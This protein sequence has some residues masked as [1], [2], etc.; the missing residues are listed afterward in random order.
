MAS[1]DA[2]S[3]EEEDL[4]D[5]ST[6]KVKFDEGSDIVMVTSQPDN[7]SPSSTPKLKASYKDMMTASEVFDFN[8]NDMV[9]AVIEE[10]SLIQWILMKFTISSPMPNIASESTSHMPN[11][12]PESTKIQDS[13]S[14]QLNTH[15]A[16]CFDP[17]MLA[18]NP[19]RRMQKYVNSNQSREGVPNGSKPSGSRFHV[20]TVDTND[21]EES[22][23]SPYIGEPNNFPPKAPPI[24]KSKNV[25]KEPTKNFGAGSNKQVSGKPK[26]VVPPKGKEIIPV[27]GDKLP[28]PIDPEKRIEMRQK[29]Y[30]MLELM[31]RYQAKLKD[32]YLN[33]GNIV[34]ILGGTTSS[35]FWDPPNL[36]SS[37]PTHILAPDI[38]DQ[39]NG[40]QPDVL[41]DKDKQ[42]ENVSSKDKPEPI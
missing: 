17:W 11:P 34:D 8:P 4:R 41:K 29:E 1:P 3:T 42:M 27:T 36:V 10:L 28:K 12:A 19:Q 23:G 9:R 40:C 14:C 2:A 37:V 32:Q 13:D 35:S 21:K 16:Q 7:L 30:E 15:Q 31:K 24:S 20:L 38:V 5:H 39:S 18:K 22:D 6:K 26:S 25:R 33:G